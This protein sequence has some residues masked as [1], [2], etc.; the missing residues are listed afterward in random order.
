MQNIAR[1]RP[2]RRLTLA[3]TLMTATLLAAN[4]DGQTKV[5]YDTDFST[6]VDDAGTLAMLHA[7]ADNGQADILGVMH[8]S[9]YVHSVAAIDVINTYYGRPNVPIGA[10]KAFEFDKDATRAFVPLIAGKYAHD[11]TRATAPDATSLYRQL[12]ASQ[13]DNSVVIVSVGFMTNLQGLMKSTADAH[14]DLGGAD[15]IQRKVK[16]VVIGSG[17]FPRS[18]EPGWN[19]SH[20]GATPYTQDVINNWPGQM[21]FVG[22]EIA[23]DIQ[24][25]S[26]LKD[27]DPANPVA[28][29]YYSFFN[30]NWGSRFSADQGVL[31]YGVGGTADLFGYVEGGYNHVYN[32][33]NNEWLT[34]QNKPNHRYLTKTAVATD[35]HLHGIIEEL[36]V[37]PSVNAPP[38]PVT[39]PEPNPNTIRINFQA[40]S[41]ETPASYLADAGNV[42]GDR[43]NGKSYGWNADNVANG[44]ERNAHGDQRYDTFNHMMKENG[45]TVWEI[46]LPDGQY[47]IT[48]VAGDPSFY[49]DSYHSIFIEDQLL[50]QGQPT[51]DSRFI[52]L[53]G[54]VLVQDGYLSLTNGPAAINNKISYIDITPVPEPTASLVSLIGVFTL[55]RRAR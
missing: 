21:T 10:L 29:S 48:L 38:P 36:M 22:N 50:L 30:N 43:G 40:A 8:N 27:S 6:D 12:L 28:E 31:L 39:P 16:E 26:A 11:Q 46:A 45:G 51:S 20:A 52:T 2:T 49:A 4:V 41:S 54:T 9:T 37:Q 18:T 7:M 15:L 19:Y 5:I 44:R 33:G 34:T 25:G 1:L 17:R 23:K 42:F 24:T 32:N 47:E 35:S 14:S 53:S 13:P 55:L 3:A